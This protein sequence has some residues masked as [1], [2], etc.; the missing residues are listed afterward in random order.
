MAIIWQE[1]RYAQKTEERHSSLLTQEV[2]VEGDGEMLNKP[3]NNYD[4]N[5]VLH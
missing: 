1:L 5:Q 4:Y 2:S 3:T